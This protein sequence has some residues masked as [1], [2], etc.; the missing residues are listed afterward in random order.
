MLETTFI[1]KLEAVDLEQVEFFTVDLTKTGGSGDF[2]CPRC[3][4]KIS[5]EDVTE[6][7]YTILETVT[8][9][10]C[11][12]KIILRCNGCGSHIHLVGFDFLSRLK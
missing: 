5:P 11:L 1:I 8:R 2:R 3:G 6:D 9:G 4:I 12:E 10:D 7:V